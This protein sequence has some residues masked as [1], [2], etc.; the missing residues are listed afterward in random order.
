MI[1]YSRKNNSSFESN[2]AFKAAKVW[3]TALGLECLS[4][5]YK[6][7]Y[8]LWIVRTPYFIRSVVIR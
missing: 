7:K 1:C 8:H 6:L 5:V 3:N 4:Y 2:T